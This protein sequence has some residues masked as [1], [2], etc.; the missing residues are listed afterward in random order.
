MMK[1]VT[2]DQ[3]LVQRLKRRDAI[4]NWERILSVARQ[5]FATQ[6]RDA[7]SMPAHFALGWQ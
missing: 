1:D 3:S 2:S 6:G 4:E 5:L 7:T